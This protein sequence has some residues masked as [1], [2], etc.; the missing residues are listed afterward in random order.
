MNGCCIGSDGSTRIRTNVSDRRAVAPRN[1]LCGAG[2][3]VGAAGYIHVGVGPPVWPRRPVL[4]RLQ[5]AVPVEKLVHL[6][7]AARCSSNA[8]TSLR[9][10]HVGA[11][12]A[13]LGL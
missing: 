5:T 1:S 2:G 12:R 11:S 9:R 10:R 13:K 6:G 8:P 7:S 4:P 3:T